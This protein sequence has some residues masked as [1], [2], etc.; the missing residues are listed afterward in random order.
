[1]IDQT[2]TLSAAQQQALADK[3][4]EFAVTVEEVADTALAL[5]SGLM[6]AMGGQVVTLDRGAAFVDNVA[7]LGPRLLAAEEG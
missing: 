2:G 6:D 1:M 4:P 5:C 7:T 3:F